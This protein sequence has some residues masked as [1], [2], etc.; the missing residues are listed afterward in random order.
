MGQHSHISTEFDEVGALLFAYFCFDLLI[1]VSGFF[2]QA[3]DWKAL[4]FSV[5]KCRFSSE[6][7]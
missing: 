1:G 7:L 3:P 6:C 2:C 4:C 5:S